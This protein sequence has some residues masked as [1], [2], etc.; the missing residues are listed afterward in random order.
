MAEVAALLERLTSGL[1]AGSRRSTVV[2]SSPSDRT[3]PSD[4]T[5]CCSLQGEKRQNVNEDISTF[6]GYSGDSGHKRNVLVSLVHT[7]LKYL[8]KLISLGLRLNCRPIFIKHTIYTSYLSDVGKLQKSF[9]DDML[10]KL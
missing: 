10:L 7:L 5:C 3:E 2:S 4:R 9:D 1:E 6:I 8:V